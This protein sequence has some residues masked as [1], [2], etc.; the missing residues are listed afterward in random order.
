MVFG[1]I[2]TKANIVIEEITRK[3]IKEA[4]YSTIQTGLDYKTEVIVVAIDKQSPVIAQSVHLQ[5]DEL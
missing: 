2:S 5:K 4:G 1:E 3:A